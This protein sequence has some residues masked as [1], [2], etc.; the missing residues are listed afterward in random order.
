MKDFVRNGVTYRGDTALLGCAIVLF[1]PLITLG[2]GVALWLLC[3]WFAP[4][5][6]APIGVAQATGL[7]LI[8]SLFAPSGRS[9]KPGDFPDDVVD[10]KSLVDKLLGNTLYRWLGVLAFGWVLHRWW[11]P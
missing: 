10:R 1:S 7:V 9:A 5:L 6:M 8:V 11:M 2:Q 3:S 4:R